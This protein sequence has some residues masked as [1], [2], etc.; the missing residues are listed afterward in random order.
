[1]PPSSGSGM[2]RQASGGSGAVTVEDR[3]VYQQKQVS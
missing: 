3:D 1:M 2:K